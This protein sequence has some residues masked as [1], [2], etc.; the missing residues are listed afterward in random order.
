MIRIGI[1][2]D[3]HNKLPSEVFSLF[4]QVN[5][6]FHAGDIGNLSILNQLSSIAPVHAVYGNTDVYPPG[7]TL[8]SRLAIRLD[9]IH[10]MMQHDIGSISS[11]YRK[12]RG[13]EVEIIPD[14]VIFGH[15]HEPLIKKHQN[16]FFM[17]PGS[18]VSPRGAPYG[19]VILLETS[20]GL[21]VR[22]D[23]VQLQE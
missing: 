3:T 18:A 4:R 2:S 17:N 15:T 19:T 22:S 23:I 11:F 16:I 10:F 12:I 1:I 5:H 21:L 20:D 7:S 13:N 14:V 9:N 8:P 6:I